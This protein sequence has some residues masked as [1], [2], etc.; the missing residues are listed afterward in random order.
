MWRPSWIFAFCAFPAKYL[1][2]CSPRLCLWVYVEM[3]SSGQPFAAR[4]ASQILLAPW[5]YFWNYVIFYDFG[6]PLGFVLKKYVLLYTF[7][8]TLIM[9][10]SDDPFRKNRVRNYC[11]LCRVY[12]SLRT[13]AHNQQNSA[14]NVLGMLKT[15]RNHMSHMKFKE[16]VKKLY[17]RDIFG[18]HFE[19]YVGNICSTLYILVYF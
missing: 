2:G 4:H 10:L 3:I 9:L 15:F 1:Q 7:R 6:S 11:N 5:V 14:R 16:T 8:Y 12:Y 19:F 17:V 18:G 13:Y